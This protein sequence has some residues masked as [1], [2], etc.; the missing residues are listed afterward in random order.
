MRAGGRVRATAWMTRS[1]RAKRT[2]RFGVAGTGS[3]AMAPAV[4]E[5][6]ADSQPT[7]HP[8]GHRWLSAHFTRQNRSIRFRDGNAQFG[9]RSDPATRSH[10]PTWA[11]PYG[12]RGVAGSERR[13][14]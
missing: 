8:Q 13:R 2:A 7:R 6:A 5:P 1:E 14:G 3:R 12:E 4:V 10:R 9:L 11:V